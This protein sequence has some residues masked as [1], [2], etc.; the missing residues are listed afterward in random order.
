MSIDLATAGGVTLAL[1]P[2]LVLTAWCLIVML[3]I[4]W[5]HEGEADQRLAAWLSLLGLASTALAVAWLWVGEARPAGLAGA[6]ALD[7]FRYLSALVFLG[8]AALTVLLSLGY[9]GRERIR[10]PEYY[11]LILLATLGMLFMGG[12]ADLVVIF[13]GLELMSVPVYVLAGVNRRSVVGAEAALKYFLLGAFASGFL[14]YGI[15]LVY[16]AT[17]TTN[18]A[19]IGAQASGFGLATNPMALI[20]LALLL[21]GFGFKV[22]A[23]PFHMW[24]PD[25]YDGAPTPITGFMAAAVKAAGF[26]ALVRMLLQ[27]FGGAPAWHEA[28]WWLAAVTMVAGNLM[29][30]AQRAL[31][32]L[33][34]YSSI[35]HAGYL[36]VAVTSGNEE[37]AAAFLFYALAYTLMT[38]GAFAV[39]AAAGR[40]GERDVLVEDLNGL[41]SRR[42]WIAA[43]MT[44]FLLSLL[45]FPGTAGFIGKWYILSSAVEAHQ[46]LLAVVLVLA[47]VIS[48][49]FYLP[50]IMAM[51]MQP[52]PSPEAHRGTVLAGAPRLVV[53]LV[54]AALLVLGV[55]PN[56]A[57]D[58][59]RDGGAGLRTAVTYTLAR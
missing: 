27:A 33:L 1:A 53:A 32:R 13:L 57:L 6:M 41:A 17:G 55:W 44:V 8:G 54:A 49:G 20:G 36:L 19:L 3:A 40:D 58:A 12:G 52:E 4:A 26:A 18:L 10:A 29:A 30:L 51:Y 38:V 24:T 56:L 43:G 14:L 28:V 59:A 34:A 45:G 21:V 2:E 31:K 5:R 37:G 23:V 39:L 48:A 47:S 11:L 35:A 46:Y 25:V 7:P 22:A 15:A 16:G 9:L 50:P 42:P